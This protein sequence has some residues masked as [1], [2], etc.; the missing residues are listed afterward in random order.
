MSPQLA[1][2]LVAAP[3][4]VIVAIITAWATLKVHSIRRE[5]RVN[6]ILPRLDVYKT[7][8]S[9]MDEVTREFPRTGTE[10]LTTEERNDIAQ[11][12]HK[13]YFSD[14]NGIFLSPKARDHFV[15]T[16][17]RLLEPSCS[18]TFMALLNEFSEMRYLMRKDIGAYEDLSV[19]ERF[20]NAFLERGRKTE[21]KA[22]GPIGRRGKGSSAAPSQHRAVDSDL[23]D[24]EEEPDAEAS[25]QWYLRNRGQHDQLPLG[26]ISARIRQHKA[27]DRRGHDG[28]PLDQ[29]DNPTHQPDKP[30]S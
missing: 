22:G 19:F 24:A 23:P 16:K 20:A 28:P 30:N 6:L 29:Q 21:T 7:L 3:F 2:A 10:E 18:I 9:L 4:T 11:A 13:W 26:T 12:L 1:A 5:R 15:E 8:W 27:E 25:D 17:D 14:G